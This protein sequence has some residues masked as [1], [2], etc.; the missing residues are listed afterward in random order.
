[1]E[2]PILPKEL[3]NSKPP[4]SWTLVAGTCA[5]LVALTLDLCPKHSLVLLFLVLWFTFPSS[6]SSLKSINPSPWF[7]KE[8]VFIKAFL[9][10]ESSSQFIGPM[11]AFEFQH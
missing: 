11:G 8:S 7:G 10:L 9:F 2:C 4:S 5:K 6:E 1:M 3:V